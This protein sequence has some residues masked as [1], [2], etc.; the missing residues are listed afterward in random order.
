M[1]TVGDLLLL[2]TTYNE[3]S[4]KH[5]HQVHANLSTEHRQLLDSL[6]LKLNRYSDA[7]VTTSSFIRLLILFSIDYLNLKEALSS[8]DPLCSLPDKSSIK[9]DIQSLGNVADM[10]GML[11]EELTQIDSLKKGEA[12][13]K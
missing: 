13:W 7:K 11:P 3:P 1:A 12:I 4:H 2:L 5:P 8:E 6:V 10:L 9:G